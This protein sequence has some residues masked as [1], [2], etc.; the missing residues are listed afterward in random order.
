MILNSAVEAERVDRSSAG[1]RRDADMHFLSELAERH[2]DFVNSLGHATDLGE[3]TFSTDILEKAAPAI[4][5]SGDA[6]ADRLQEGAP[7]NSL[8][9]ELPGDFPM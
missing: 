1:P 6:L 2:E 7:K 8:K 9:I 4:A 3:A 5:L